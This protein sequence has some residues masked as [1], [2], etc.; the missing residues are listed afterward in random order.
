MRRMS[1]S[2]MKERLTENVKKGIGGSRRGRRKPEERRKG[3]T[4][5]GRRKEQGGRERKGMLGGVEGW[6]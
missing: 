1:L 2:G 3:P 4:G 6:A 5:R